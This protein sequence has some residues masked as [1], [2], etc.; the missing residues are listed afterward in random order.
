MTAAPHT[1]P[2]QSGTH[3]QMPD[4]SLVTVHPARLEDLYAFMREA[5]V[6]KRS[7][8]TGDLVRFAE[9]PAEVEAEPV[10]AE[11][12]TPVETPVE[13][14]VKPLPARKSKEA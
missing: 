8:T 4:G 12:Q 11:V 5:A 10:P 9:P 1:T 3:I 14:V 13:E 6:E 2:H 7:L